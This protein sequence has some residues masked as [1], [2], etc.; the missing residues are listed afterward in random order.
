MKHTR[1]MTT[2]L[3][4]ATALCLLFASG[5][6]ARAE[7]GNAAAA[8]EQR[9]L[10]PCT[11]KVP[12]GP[13]IEGVFDT[14]WWPGGIVPFEFDGNVTQAEED[15]MLDAMTEWEAVA[16]VDFRP[17][18]GENDYIHIEDSA[19]NRSFVGMQG[20]S[21]AVEIF[22]WNRRFTMV[23]E[24]GHALGL[25]HEQSRTDRDDYVAIHFERILADDQN[26]F[27][28]ET[29][30]HSYG[31]YDFDSVMHYDQCAFSFC[32]AHDE[33]CENNLSH[34]RTILVLEPWHTQWQDAIGQRDRLSNLDQLTMQMMYPWSSWVFVDKSNTGT[35][36][37][38][39]LEPWDTFPE[40]ADDVPSDGTVIIQPGTYTGCGGT[41]TKHMTLRAPIDGVL[42]QN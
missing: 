42:L 21:Q 36:N 12:E 5:T 7:D 24:L 39:F 17:R 29:G 25:W 19:F 4:A 38:T 11:I 40:G 31:E 18:N 35:E 26:N 10:R 15:A 3:A 37:G 20:G 30:S 9:P 28:L 27:D 2:L 14:N 33:E 32:D 41:Y 23:H 34:C 1:Q 13:R 22:N 8:P 16:D 6:A